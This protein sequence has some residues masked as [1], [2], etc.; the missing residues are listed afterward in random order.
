LPLEREIHLD[1]TDLTGQNSKRDMV[2]HV[3]NSNTQGQ[4]DLEFEVSLGYTVKNK[5]KTNNENNQKK[6]KPT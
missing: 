6:K 1:E 4:E 2:A 5:T 3:C